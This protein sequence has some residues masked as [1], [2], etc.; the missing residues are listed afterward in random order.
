MSGSQFAKN[1]NCFRVW[2]KKCAI[3]SSAY[4]NRF[5]DF[6]RTDAQCFVLPDSIRPFGLRA[7]FSKDRSIITVAILRCESLPLVAASARCQANPGHP[8]RQRLRSQIYLLNPPP[9][10]DLRPTST[11]RRELRPTRCRR[12]GCRGSRPSFSPRDQNRSGSRRDRTRRRC[13]PRGSGGI[14][15]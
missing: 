8:L 15:P 1:Q 11:S 6:D 14:A 9:L 7:S 2:S 5:H 13:R 3:G 4:E 12:R 10:P